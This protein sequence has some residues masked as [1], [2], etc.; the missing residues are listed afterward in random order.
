MVMAKQR[1][2]LLVDDEPSIIK[3]VGKRLELAGYEVLTALDGQDGLAKAKVG[4]PDVIILD[5]MMPKLS[6]F[7]VCNALK[8]DPAYKHI[9][10]IIFTG[11]GQE[12]DERLCRELGAEAYI[13][14]PHDATTLL[15][16]IEALLSHVLPEEGSG[17][18]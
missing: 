11:K 1:R 12:M 10:I 7:E 2:V 15:E 8:A 4:R 5:L 13:S 17:A 16:Q 6:G 18:Q 3:T 9:P 14:K